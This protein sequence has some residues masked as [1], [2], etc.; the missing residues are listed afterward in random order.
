MKLNILKLTSITA[1]ACN[2]TLHAHAMLTEDLLN[3]CYQYSWVLN[4][5]PMKDNFPSVSK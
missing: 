2:T 4:S 1:S 3:E 5:D